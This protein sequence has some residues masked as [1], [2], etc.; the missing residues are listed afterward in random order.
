MNEHDLREAHRAEPPPRRRGWRCPAEDQLAAF[1]DE[2]LPAA[3]RARVASH[4]ADCG[5]CRDQVAFLALSAETEPPGEVPAGLLAQARE[6]VERKAQAPRAWRWAPATAVAGCLVVVAVV[7][8]R[9]Q[10]T[11]PAAI[12]LPAPPAAAVPSPAISPAPAT[13]LA[14]KRRLV[15]SGE[16]RAA[17]PQLVFPA[18]GAILSR[19]R[20]AFRWNPAPGA[21]FYEVRVLTA[22]G[23]LVWEGR[24]EGVEARVPGS[25]SLAAGARYYVSVSGFLSDGKTIKFPTVG[26][27]VAAGE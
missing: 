10:E 7:W 15:R 20:V 25:I 19:E 18:E 9:R 8:M 14:E 13:A 11:G 16:D 24:A 6:L 27:Q 12:P 4:V 23:D 5:F 2:R 21:L 3:R 17:A 1:V 22:E 26:F